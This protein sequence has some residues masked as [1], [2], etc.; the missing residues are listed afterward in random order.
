MYQKSLFIIIGLLNT[1]DALATHYGLSI[2]LVDEQNPF[3]LYLWDIH[4]YLFLTVK[5]LFTL[6]IFYF[7]LFTQKSIWQKK[8]WTFILTS[9]TLIYLFV[10]GVHL[11]W[12]SLHFNLITL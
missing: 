6:L 8:R 7:P 1:T 4:P 11:L 10:N 9:V 12:L 2:G 3:A 5:I